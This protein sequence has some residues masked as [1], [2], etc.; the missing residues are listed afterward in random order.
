MF[1][2]LCILVSSGV[3]SIASGIRSPTAARKTYNPTNTG[4]GKGV[5]RGV[6]GGVKGAK[7][8]PALEVSYCRLPFG[9]LHYVKYLIM[10]MV[11]NF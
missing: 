5:G 3:Q 1:L 4:I 7:V 11:P 8:A 9:F 2:T 10:K 6:A